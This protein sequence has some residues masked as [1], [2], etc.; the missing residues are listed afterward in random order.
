[1]LKFKELFEATSRVPFKKGQKV[2]LDGEILFVDGVSYEEMEGVTVISFKD[3]SGKRCC[4]YELNYVE[5]N[6][7]RL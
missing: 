6:A 7:K 2:K 5:R 3:T 4:S 1:M